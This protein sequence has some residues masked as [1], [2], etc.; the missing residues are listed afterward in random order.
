MCSVLSFDT[1]LLSGK[2]GVNSNKLF[3]SIAVII[4]ISWAVLSVA[5]SLALKRL[6]FSSA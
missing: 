2:T 4:T 6:G 3:S 5:A 1:K